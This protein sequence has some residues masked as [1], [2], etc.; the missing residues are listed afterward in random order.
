MCG[1]KKGWSY[2]SPVIIWKGTGDRIIET[3]FIISSQVD[4]EAIYIVQFYTKERKGE[5]NNCY[6]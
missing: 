3:C 5:E 2:L 6:S 4:M 1:G